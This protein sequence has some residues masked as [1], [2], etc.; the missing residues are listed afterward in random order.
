MRGTAV[1]PLIRRLMDAQGVQSKDLA[2]RMGVNVQSVCEWRRNGQLPSVANAE[3]LAEELSAPS[4]LTLVTRART[5]TCD[6]CKRPFVQANS[7]GR[8]RRYCSMRCQRTG[9]SEMR[10]G[11]NKVI[12]G[13][14]HTRWQNRYRRAQDAIDLMCNECADW[15]GVC[16]VAECPLRELSPLPLVKEDVA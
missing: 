15:E 2:E 6:V 3:K 14:V 10:K 4:I 1:G 9:T 11:A 8:K 7:G 13:K 5:L 16:R 12:W